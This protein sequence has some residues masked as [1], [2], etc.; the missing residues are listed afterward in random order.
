[1]AKD[2][3]KLKITLR[4]S[5]ISRPAKHK[6]V[7]LGLGLRKVNGTVVRPDTPEIRGMI[8]MVRHLVQV[9]NA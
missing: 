4:R 7:L 5:A 2:S 8:A 3:K 1:M 9:E 6:S